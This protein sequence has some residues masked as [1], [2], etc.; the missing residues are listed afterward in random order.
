MLSSTIVFLKW[1]FL[2]ILF[3]CLD[4]FRKREGKS[5]LD[6]DFLKRSRSSKGLQI[7]SPLTWNGFSAVLS[8][9]RLVGFV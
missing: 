3:K 6:A 2:P 5:S 8:L 1:Q 7:I 4:K 9:W